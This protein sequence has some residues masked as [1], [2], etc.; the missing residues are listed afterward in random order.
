MGWFILFLVII[1][2]GC[3]FAYKEGEIHE[4]HKVRADFMKFEEAHREI[5]NLIGFEE[6]LKKLEDDLKDF[7]IF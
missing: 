6:T 5:K 2:F 1:I 7:D 3:Y 4:L